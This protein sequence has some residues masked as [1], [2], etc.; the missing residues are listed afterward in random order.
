MQP[1]SG[2]SRS[3]S[4]HHDRRA[5]E[6]D[7][8]VEPTEMQ[9]RR[10]RPMAQHQHRLDQPGDP[11]RRLGMADVAFDRTHP[12]LPLACAKDALQRVHLDRVAQGGA[13][14]VR[15]DVVDPL[16]RHPGI[17]QGGADYRLLRRPV[18]CGQPGA[19]PVLVDGAA[20]QHRQHPVARRPRRRQQLQ[21]DDAAAFAM[22]KSIGR[23][24]ERAAASGRRSGAK[25]AARHQSE[26]RQDQ[27]HPARQREAAFAAAQCLRRQM[28]R[29]ERGRAGGV[30]RDRR[31]CQ[32]EMKGDAAGCYAGVGPRGRPAVE[33]RR[34]GRAAPDHPI[35]VVVQ[36][37]ID[38][39]RRAA[40]RVG[41]DA[42]MLE[43]LPGDLQ[44]KALL[45]VHL[46]RLARGDAEK[47]RIEHVD[48][49]E[50]PALGLG[51]A[52]GCGGIGAEPTS[53]VP[54]L[55]RDRPHRVATARQQLPERGAAIRT[56]GE[57]TAEADDCDRLL[58]R[59][60]AHSALAA[61][62]GGSKNRLERAGCQAGSVTTRFGSPV[63]SAASSAASAIIGGSDGARPPSHKAGSWAMPTPCQAHHAIDC[64][65]RSAA[66]HASAKPSRNPFAAA[67]PAVPA[68]PNQAAVEENS[69]KSA[70]SSPARGSQR[71]P[72]H[73]RPSLEMPETAGPTRPR[74]RGHRR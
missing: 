10:H 14:A 7:M 71:A 60:G 51:R 35:I 6:I 1:R 17:L 19:P 65:L 18:G 49:R 58:R 31:R 68:R 38:P 41:G 33:Q 59:H 21:H 56:T 54:A 72:R 44:G 24:I 74:R 3:C 63:A 29:D 36:A 28:H 12:Q 57:P 55:G 42:S 69:T 27:V 39:G 37:E 45:R 16:R 15:L 9:A 22:H 5:R 64:T 52:A 40:Q 2:F 32:A 26:R 53:M 47:R 25:L 20:A 43:R 48:R 50:K 67:Y 30:D 23:G 73:R 13:G 66:L 34:V 70:S 62:I 61:N 46:H 8:R 11:G 4:R